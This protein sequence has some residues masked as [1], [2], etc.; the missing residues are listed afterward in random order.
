MPSSF[1]KFDTQCMQEALRL[2]WKGRYSTNPNPRVGC[3]IADENRQVI[4][5]R[6]FHDHR[7]GLHAEMAALSQIKDRDLSQATVYS[8]LEPCSHQGHT[9]PCATALCNKQVKRVVAAMSDP[10]PL[11]HLSLI[12]ISEPTRPY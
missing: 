5:A 7:G 9:G 3:V 12:H 2:A 11:V 4:L 10:N 1:S 8:T 6:C